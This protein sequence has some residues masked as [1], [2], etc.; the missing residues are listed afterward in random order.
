MTSRRATYFIFFLG[1]A[2]LLLS[3]CGGSGGGDGTQVSVDTNQPVETETRASLFLLSEAQS[4]RVG[5]IL[6]AAIILDTKNKAVTAVSAY[7]IFPSDLLEVASINREE[8][9]F[10]MGVEAI[11]EDDLIRIT[12]GEP[13]PGVNSSDAIV[14]EIAFIAKEPG[15][16]CLE[17][18]LD[19]PSEGPSRVI[20]ADGFGTDILDIVT[21]G[22][23]T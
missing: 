22:C 3:S 10:S 2:F 12:I 14:A 23:Y 11:A 20:S 1:L 5:N 9:N 7:I 21:G 13:S 17:F 15:I 16:A 18:F 19:D 8:S 4:V 6:T